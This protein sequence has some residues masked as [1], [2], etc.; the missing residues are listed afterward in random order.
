CEAESLVFN[1]GA[2]QRLEPRCE[3]SLGVGEQS[4]YTA[5]QGRLAGPLPA[6]KA[7]IMDAPHADAL[8]RVRAA[9][10]A[11]DPERDLA[12]TDQPSKHAAGPSV[13]PNVFG[14]SL[15]RRERTVKVEEQRQVLR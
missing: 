15:K 3:L 5:R 7:G 14:P 11:D 12:M 10:P 2:G 8:P 1:P 9:P 6:V 13:Q 4:S